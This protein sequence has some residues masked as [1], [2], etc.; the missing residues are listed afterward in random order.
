ME[1]KIIDLDHKG[2]GIARIDNSKVI[3]VL[4]SGYLDKYKSNKDVISIVLYSFL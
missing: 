3:S 1:V 2:N 4:L